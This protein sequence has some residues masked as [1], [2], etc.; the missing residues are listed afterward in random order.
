MTVASVPGAESTPT[1]GRARAGRRTKDLVKQL[2]PGEIAVIDH[3]DLDVV[4]A[5]ALLAAGVIAVVNA[6]SSFSGRYAN[7][8]PR[9]LL[10]AGVVVLDD[11]GERLLDIVDDGAVLMLDGDVVRV[12]GEAVAAGHR[13]DL[14]ELDERIARARAN[15]GEQLEQFASNTLEY[16]RRERHLA[17]DRPDLPP[18]RVEF[19][20]RHALIVVRGVD[21]REDLATLQRSGYLREVKPVLIAVDGGADA[22]LALGHTPDI[23]IGDMDSVSASALRC[24]AELIVH[25]FPG[26][27][28]P[29]AARLDEL[30][31]TSLRFESAG[32]SEDI[33]MLLAFE[34]GAE[35][36]VAVGTHTSMEDFLDKGRAG[37]ASTFLVRMKVGRILVDARGV[38]RLYRPVVSSRDIVV[39]AAAM[40]SSLVLVVA[41]SEPLRLWLR[42]VW[43]WARARVGW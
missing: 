38:N 29:G 1:V 11:V 34:R 16:L 35:L 7:L 31:I 2:E 3:L 23:I 14:A 26:G 10:G 41:M 39:F 17:T 42:S 9:L 4:A 33:A 13:L 24:G 32:T 8:G 12:D 18:T 25:A 43:L 20:G 19:T 5:E 21:Y 37:M 28:A 27:R 36:I 22:L 6:S 15:M 40:L 30:D